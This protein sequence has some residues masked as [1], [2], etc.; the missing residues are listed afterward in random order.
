MLFGPKNTGNLTLEEQ[1]NLLL[2]ERAIRDVIYRECRA[3]NRGDAE[4]KYTCYFEDLVDH[5]EPFFVGKPHAA[6]ETGDNPLASVAEM[7]QYAATQILID[8]DG[9]SARVE[10]YI[11]ATKIV[12][13]R[14][15]A[16]NKIIRLAGNRHL[17]RFE[18]RDGEWRIAG[19]QFIPEWGLFQEVPPLVEPISIYGI[20][21]DAGT[22]VHNQSM[23]A[24]G[25]SMD[26]SDLSY[27]PT[28]LF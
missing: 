8:L 11:L 15:E 26:T 22:I 12:N 18:K 17:D 10:S 1:V 4:L 2:D 27:H 7:V 25:H 9:N 14:S 5:H 23:P 20:G 24:V 28:Y 6:A 21:T 16:G 3:K 19:R 13:Q